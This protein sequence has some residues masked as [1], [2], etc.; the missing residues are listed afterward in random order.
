[1]AIEVKWNE[2][3]AAYT[4]AEFAEGPHAGTKVTIYV[5]NLKLSLL[6]AGFVKIDDDVREELGLKLPDLELERDEER[7]IGPAILRGFT[8]D[9]AILAAA[10]ELWDAVTHPGASRIDWYT[11]EPL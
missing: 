9:P 2:Y 3:G 8:G 11:G 7:Q 4:E 1:M 5:D 6:Q 10:M